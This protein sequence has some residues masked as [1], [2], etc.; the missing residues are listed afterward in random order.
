MTAE[1]IGIETV[2]ECVEHFAD[3][4]LLGVGRDV[5]QIPRGGDVHH[6]LE[7]GADG[8]GLAL[9]L[10]GDGVGGVIALFRVEFARAIEDTDRELWVV[11][12]DV[13]SAYFVY[14][15]NEEPD[16]AFEQYCLLME[17]WATAVRAG[18]SLDEVVPVDAPTTQANADSLLSRI[19][20]IR[21]V[22]IGRPSAES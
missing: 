7:V 20:F 5:E 3:G 11:V 21:E 18:G 10:V 17:D 19:A 2:A 8:L 6:V 15:G 22:L 12:G 1:G 13:P 4:V 14:E 9:L 16:V